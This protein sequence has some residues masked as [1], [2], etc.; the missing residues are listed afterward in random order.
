MDFEKIG[1]LVREVRRTSGRR[2]FGQQI[3]D[4]REDKP[5]V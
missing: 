3:F 4:I 1:F 2:R 5:A